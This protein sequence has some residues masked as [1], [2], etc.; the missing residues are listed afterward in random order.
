MRLLLHP[1]MPKKNFNAQQDKIVLGKLIAK[2]RADKNISLRQMAQGINIPPSNLT[3][4]EDG[5]NVP[6]ADVYSR[7]IDFLNPINKVQ[8]QMDDLY[9]KIRHAPPPDVCNILIENKGLGE[10]IKLLQNVS[11]SPEQLTSIEELFASF[12]K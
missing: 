4:I 1:V 5:R 12:K 10:R 3:Y 6:T 11:L 9:T 2:L 7:I 8:K